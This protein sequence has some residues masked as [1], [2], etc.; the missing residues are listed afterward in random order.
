L[1]MIP[2]NGC[3]DKFRFLRRKARRRENRRFPR[4]RRFRAY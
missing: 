3:D 1:Y 4:G 2:Q